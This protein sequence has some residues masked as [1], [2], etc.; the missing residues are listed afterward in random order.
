VSYTE[1]PSTRVPGAVVW[2]SVAD[3]AGR[4]IPDGCSD[5]LLIGDRLVIAG[6]DTTAKVGE[7]AAG[8]PIQGLR[9]APGWGP[10]VYGVP[11]DRVRDQRVPLDHVW[12]PATVRLLEGRLAEGRVTLEAIAVE[13]LDAAAPPSAPIVEAARCLAAGESVDATADAVGLS[14]RQL[15]RL[16]HESFGYGPKL[17]VRVLR[18]N[19]A[20]DRVRSGR[21]AA[22]AAAETGY[23]DQAHLCRDVKDLTGVT[24][25]QLVGSSA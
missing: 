11:A 7:V 15:R 16:A 14:P 5:L 22:D 24:L 21:P 1:R 9:F 17:L 18:L 8:T 3:G 12:A 13:R 6:P 25:G 20:L 10:A 19:Q 23:V 4:V 2:R